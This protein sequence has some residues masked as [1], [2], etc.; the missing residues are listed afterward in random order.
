[1]PLWL[2]GIAAR[3]SPIGTFLK[4]VSFKAWLIIL[5]CIVTIV[6]IWVIE[7][8]VDKYFKHVREIEAHNAELDKAN[9]GWQ[10]SYNQAIVT[11]AENQHLLNSE[12][13]TTVKVRDIANSEITLA[14]TRTAHYKDIRDAALRTK[15]T[16]DCPIDPVILNTVDRLWNSTVIGSPGT[17]DNRP[18]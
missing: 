7:L 4:G 10:A 8:K 11:N 15:V 17:S 9:R 14:N 6:A 5:G 16:T 18:K 2:I 13:Q 1:M 3:F 12:R